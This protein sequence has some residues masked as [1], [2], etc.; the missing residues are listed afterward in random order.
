MGEKKGM[1]PELAEI[2]AE[3]EAA[4]GPAL[5]GPRPASPEESL[6]AIRKA[7]RE[8]LEQARSLRQLAAELP[9]PGRGGG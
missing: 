3:L 2:I 4:A 7:V 1:P 5:P 8:S 6:A 9:E